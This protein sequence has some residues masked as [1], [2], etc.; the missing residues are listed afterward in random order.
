MKSNSLYRVIFKNFLPKISDANSY[1]N[2]I[3]KH[4]KK[5]LYCLSFDDEVLVAYDFDGIIGE[6]KEIKIDEINPY[7]SIKKLRKPIPLKLLK[8]KFDLPF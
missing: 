3:L 6:C 8:R 1:C 2:I 5:T 7:C 4:R